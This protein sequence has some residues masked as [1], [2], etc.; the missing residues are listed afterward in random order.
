MGSHI[1]ELVHDN[2]CEAT[3]DEAR[4]V[5]RYSVYR[6][7]GILPLVLPVFFGKRYTDTA[8]LFVS[9]CRQTGTVF[10]VICCGILAFS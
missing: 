1:H 9:V 10:S 4:D 2:E 7:A 3:M 8:I 5:H 6:N